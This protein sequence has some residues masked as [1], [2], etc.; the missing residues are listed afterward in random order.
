MRENIGERVALHDLPIRETEQN[1][2][3]ST[4]IDQ[5]DKQYE[6]YRRIILKVQEKTNQSDD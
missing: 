6:D 2:I 1:V 3:A 5:V 4:L